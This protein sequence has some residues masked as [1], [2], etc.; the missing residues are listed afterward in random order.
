M[1]AIIIMLHN[2]LNQRIIVNQFEKVI[3]T[4][5]SGLKACQVLSI[6]LPNPKQSQVES[7][8]NLKAEL[9]NKVDFEDVLAFIVESNYGF[10]SEELVDFDLLQFGLQSF[11]NANIIAYSSTLHSL[12]MAAKIDDRVKVCHSTSTQV[13]SIIAAFNLSQTLSQEDIENITGRVFTRSLDKELA[14]LLISEN[15][16]NGELDM[17]N[18]AAITFAVKNHINSD[19]APTKTDDYIPASTFVSTKIHQ[20]P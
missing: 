1:K 10:P 3:R 14:A 12:A 20:S 13:D 19:L 4:Q 7:M 17:N 9:A 15:S 5:S 8:A 16:E 18:P 6:P 2:R 11:P